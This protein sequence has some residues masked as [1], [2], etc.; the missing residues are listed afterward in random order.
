MDLEHVLLP[1]DRQNHGPHTQFSSSTDAARPF[2]P[3]STAPLRQELPRPA[4]YTSVPRLQE[5]R[6]SSFSFSED[7]L[8]PMTT[9]KS[10][11]LLSDD[12]SGAFEDQDL[13]LP[14][15]NVCSKSSTLPSDPKITVQR[16]LFVLDQDPYHQLH[17][18]QI[19]AGAPSNGNTHQAQ[20]VETVGKVG[21]PSADSLHKPR[22][23]TKT[24]SLGRR[25]K[26]SRSNS[27]SPEKKTELKSQ[28][29]AGI[30]GRAGRFFIRENSLKSSKQLDDVAKEET[31]TTRAMSRGRTLL[32]KRAAKEQPSDMETSSNSALEPAAGSTKMSPAPLLKSLSNNNIHSLSRAKQDPAQVPPL[33]SSEKLS[34]IKDKPPKRKDELWA[35]FRSLESDYARFHAKSTALK[36]NVVRSGLLT[37]LRDFADHPSNANLRPEDLDRRTNILNKWWVGLL[38]L[39]QGKNGNSISGSD[40]PVILDAI[41]GIMERREWRYPPSSFAPLAERAEQSRHHRTESTA[42]AGSDDFLLESVHHNV[43]NM[44]VQNLFAQM[45][46]VVD[47]MSL[48]HTPASSVAFCG[49]A[50]AYAFFFCPGIAE[51][52]VRLWGLKPHHLK[53]VL[54]VSRV[55][56]TTDLKPA[57]D[58]AASN[59]PSVM[60][61]LVFTSARETLKIM[62]QSSVLP[63]GVDRLQWHGRWLNHWSGRDSE[64]FYA[65]VRCFHQLTLEFLPSN[66]TARDRIVAPGF[67]LVQAQMLS[68]LESTIHRQSSHAVG[69]PTADATTTFEEILNVDSPTASLPSSP[70]NA[71]RLMSDNR[72]ILLLKDLIQARAT[73]GTAVVDFFASTF[74][75]VLQATVRSTSLY[76]QSAC[77][78][79]CD[80]LQEALP[81]LVPYQVSLPPADQP[82]PWSFITVIFKKM[83]DS[84]NTTTEIRLYAMIF[85]IWEVIVEAQ[86]WR[87]EVSLEFLLDREYFLN[88][89]SH[90]CPMV[91]AYYMRLLCWRLGRY[92]G[93]ATESEM[94]IYKTLTERLQEAWAYYRYFDDLSRRKGTLRPSTAPCN[95]APGRKLL[96]IRTDTQIPTPLL[97]FSN[98][99]SATEDSRSEQLLPTEASHET[100]TPTASSIL[101]R[102]SATLEYG[103][104][105]SRRRGSLLRSLWGTRTSEPRSRSQSPKRW[106]SGVSSPR[107]SKENSRRGSPDQ[108]ISRSSLYEQRPSQLSPDRPVKDKQSI[109]QTERRPRFAHA[110]F[111]FSLEAVDRRPQVT[112]SDMVLDSP[113]LP[114]AAQLLLESQPTFK[115]EINACMPEQRY[116]TTL[117]YVGRALAEWTWVVNECQNFFERRRSEGVP[118]NREVETPSLSVEPFRRLG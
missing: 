107:A 103:V 71:V 117:R 85:S 5:S 44:F 52:L 90:W 27:R 57:A 46:F 91:R 43:R 15:S 51:I 118:S 84:Q 50:C 6:E 28:S 14:R 35:P 45:A 7:D 68:N 110:D 13:H 89:F 59:F 33:T 42:S 39:I 66:A 56:S 81:I 87:D 83:V 41:T 1:T 61:S 109:P 100:T 17:S 36:A 92:D 60:R 112:A 94:L 53:H 98:L 70:I 9:N 11:D 38:D 37:F 31:M 63:L 3:D 101:D 86:S 114:L 34:V 105:I 75:S 102:V 80:F 65:F 108:S 67:M 104:D 40:R 20:N 47:K 96:I 111:K 93:N 72:L 69:E 95:P 115:N 78:T 73:V 8:V 19:Q 82:L 54:R 32:S 18:P 16:T 113:R 77:F 74:C 4:S 30:S 64:L 58:V 23:L 48:K 10:S 76:D 2:D 62:R 25:A 24:F 29:Q 79:L 106:H 22:P 21:T 99:I 55:R 26:S 49:K 116:G 97:N 88:T 12:Y